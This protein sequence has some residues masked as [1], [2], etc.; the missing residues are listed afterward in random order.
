MVLETGRVNEMH[1]TPPLLNES[2]V[3]ERSRDLSR[4]PKK[5]ANGNR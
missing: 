1:H 4:P 2:G 5:A 3:L